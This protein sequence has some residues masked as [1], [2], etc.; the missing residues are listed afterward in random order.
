[1]HQGVGV[2]GEDPPAL[3]H[4]VAVQPD[5]EGLGRLVPELLQGPDDAV[6]DGVAGGD[7]AEHVDEDDLDLRV[8]EDDVQPVGHDLCGGATADVEEVGGLGQHPVGAGAD[9]LT[10]VG[11]D[12]QGA[13]HQA[14]A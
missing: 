4:V 9:V 10:G 6:G 8:G 7:A 3:L 2:V 11:D 14:G 12:V 13:H 1:D 5:D